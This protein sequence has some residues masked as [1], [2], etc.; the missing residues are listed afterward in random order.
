M[1]QH[2]GSWS[3]RY[4]D[5]HAKETLRKREIFLTESTLLL[6][7]K[8]EAR[9]RNRYLLREERKK[10]EK[11][12][13]N[14]V[15]NGDYLIPEIDYPEQPKERPG[16]YGTMRGMYLKSM[17]RAVYLQMKLDGTLHQHLLDV[18][19]RAD[20]MMEEIVNRLAQT[21]PPPDKGSDQMGW[22]QHM[23]ALKVQAE[24]TVIA[25]VVH[26]K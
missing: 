11:P 13:L 18:D 7:M 1:K 26:G 21:D 10:M 23:N 24:E 16:R 20:A 3:G 9:T 17:R 19:Q 12:T 8:T 2:S 4:E 22:V 6:I 14:Y 5:R 25:E 15:Q